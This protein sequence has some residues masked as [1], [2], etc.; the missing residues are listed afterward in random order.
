MGELIAA[1]M[2]FCFG[3]GMFTAWHFR[4]W[5]DRRMRPTVIASADV[6]RIHKSWVESLAAL[7]RRDRK[8]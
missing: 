4:G 6:A 7:E 1:L 2:V 8:S 5:Y 3:C